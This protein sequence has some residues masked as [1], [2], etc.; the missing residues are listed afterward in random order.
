M[1]HRPSSIVHRQQQHQPGSPVFQPGMMAAI[2][3]G[4]D[5]T[6]IQIAIDPVVESSKMFG[7][8]VTFTDLSNLPYQV[9]RL[10]RKLLKNRGA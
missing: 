7:K 9:G 8:Y 2:Q 6:V 1:R 3:L 10:L 5:L 4:K